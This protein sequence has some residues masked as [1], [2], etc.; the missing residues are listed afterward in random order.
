MAG[1]PHA[2]RQKM[3]SRTRQKGRHSSAKRPSRARSSFG[4]RIALLEGRPITQ[5]P[6]GVEPGTGL[7][8]SIVQAVA[9]AHGAKVALASAAGAGATFRVTLPD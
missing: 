9:K 1:S 5:R 7:G 8:L 3:P 6:P 4:A 2:V